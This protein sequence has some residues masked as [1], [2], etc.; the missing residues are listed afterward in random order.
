MTREQ[1]MEI[2]LRD[3]IRSVQED[4][5]RKLPDT[6]RFSPIGCGLRIPD[7]VYLAYI[8]VECDAA[9]HHGRRVRVRVLREG[10]DRAYEQIFLEMTSAEIRKFLASPKAYRQIRSAVDELC[11]KIQAE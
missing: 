11:A 3:V 1:R 4:T 2:L 10:T 8:I 6:H 9:N 7:T 5:V